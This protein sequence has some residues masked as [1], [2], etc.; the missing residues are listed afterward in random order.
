MADDG[1]VARPYA[2][3]IFDIAVSA[4]TLAQWSDALAA[5]ASVVSDAAARTYLGR[6]GLAAGERAEFVAGI[7][8]K[9]PDA[10]LLASSQG[11]ALLGLL[12][13]NERLAALPEIAA[14][15]DQLKIRAENKINVQLVSAVP[16][17]REVAVKIAQS[18]E[19]RLGRKVDLELEVDETLMGGAIVRAEDMVID[20]SVRSRLQRLADS[21]I[22]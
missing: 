22:H 10:G 13:E 18:L 3:A 4:G 14:Q 1:T 20:G 9:I 19:Q 12:D 2:R 11:R 7:C 16:V 17:D 6:P 15:F 21:L 5:A 8:A